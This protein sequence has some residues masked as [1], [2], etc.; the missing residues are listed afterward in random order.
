MQAFTLTYSKL[1]RALISEVII[2]IIHTLV[3]FLNKLE[4]TIFT[5]FVFIIYK[6]TN[7]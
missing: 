3:W 7:L 4:L 1:S 2:T 5:K 6:L